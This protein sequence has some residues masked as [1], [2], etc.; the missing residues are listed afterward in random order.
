MRDIE[1]NSDK[2]TAFAVVFF[3]ALALF[4]LFDDLHALASH[5]LA[6]D[7]VH[8]WDYGVA[9]FCLYIAVDICRDTKLRKNYRFGVAGVGLLAFSVILK[10][11]AHWAASP[12]TRNLLWTSMRAVEIVAWGLILVEGVRWLRKIATV[13]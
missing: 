12:D 2:Y 11:V 6:Q 13:T 7:D 4:G 3:L 8:F 10:M 9:I 5:R 1:I